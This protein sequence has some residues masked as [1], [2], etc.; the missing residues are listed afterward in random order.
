M[1]RQTEN[2]VTVVDDM[3]S[4]WSSVESVC[5]DTHENMCVTE[6]NT[7]FVKS[8]ELKWIVKSGEGC[9]QMDGAAGILNNVQVDM[10]ND[11]KYLSEGNAT[12]VRQQ[13][14]IRCKNST[15]KKL[16]NFAK[17]PLRFIGSRPAENSGTVVD[18]V[19]SRR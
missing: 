10:K 6:Q 16:R 18:G 5:A 14:E 8:G 15:W 4:H 1:R 2:S 9:N 12:S 7:Q 11:S 19:G 17:R 13:V 3:G